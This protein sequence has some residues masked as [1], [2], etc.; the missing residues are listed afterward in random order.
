MTLLLFA[1]GSVHSIG[2]NISQAVLE[3]LGHVSDGDV[4]A[5][6]YLPFEKCHRGIF[7]PRQ[8]QSVALRGSQ[9][10]DLRRYFGIASVRSR[11]PSRKSTD[12]LRSSRRRE[13]TSDF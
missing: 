8:A 6:L 2:I 3:D 12:C 1:D 7:Q 4:I 13:S 5:D 10:N 9:T 11:S